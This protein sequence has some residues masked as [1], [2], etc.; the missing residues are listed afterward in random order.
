MKIILL[1][2]IYSFSGFSCVAYLGD[3]SRIQSLSISKVLKDK[4]FSISEL[5]IGSDIQVELETKSY[6]NI[7]GYPHF[8]M[9]SLKLN[10]NF[11]DVQIFSTYNSDGFPIYL[12]MKGITKELKNSSFQCI[13]SQ[14]IR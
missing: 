1:I 2:M 3:M 14:V 11:D 13:D 4:G 10:V 7:H 9:R 6:F 8:F 5:K 12:G